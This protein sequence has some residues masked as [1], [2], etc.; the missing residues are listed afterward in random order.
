ME[1]NLLCGRSFTIL[2]EFP[3]TTW[4]IEGKAWSAPAKRI[5]KGWNLDWGMSRRLDFLGPTMA[6]TLLYLCQT[7]WLWKLC[8]RT[9]SERRVTYNGTIHAYAPATSI[10]AS[11]ASWASRSQSPPIAYSLF[12]FPDSLTCYGGGS[13]RFNSHG[14]DWWSI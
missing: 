12:P 1:L 10:F 14:L 11:R 8:H 9:I 7:Y 2:V 6:M 13:L 4:A 5:C 3:G